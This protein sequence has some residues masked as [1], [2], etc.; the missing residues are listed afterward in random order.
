MRGGER[1]SYFM[2]HHIIV[3]LSQHMSILL[4][5]ALH[6]MSLFHMCHQYLLRCHV[7]IMWQCYKWHHY[8]HL[9]LSYHAA[10][11][12]FFFFLIPLLFLL[13]FMGVGFRETGAQS[14][15]HGG[16]EGEEGQGVPQTTSKPHAAATRCA[17]SLL[18]SSGDSD[19]FDFLQLSLEE[20]DLTSNS[21]FWVEQD[22]IG[23]N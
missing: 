15:G 14:G 8:L 4:W 1:N 3:L 6:L 7:F 2:G 12:L 19:A 23:H 11:H 21:I 10:S 22:R 18:F 9:Y 16:N 17:V 13:L 20:E 5:S